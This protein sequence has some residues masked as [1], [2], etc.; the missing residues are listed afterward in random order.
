MLDFDLAMRSPQNP[1]GREVRRAEDAYEDVSPRAASLVESLRAFGYDLATAIAD[2]VDNSIFNGAKHVWIH[3]HWQGEQ[4]SIAIIDDGSGMDETTL[5]EAMRL[6]TTNPRDVRDPRDLGR[7]GLGLKTA[8]FSQCRKVTVRTRQKNQPVITRCWDLDHIARVDAW[9]LSRSGGAAAAELSASL[10]ALAEGTAVIWEKMDRLVAG[11]ETEND[12]HEASF[13]GRADAVREHLATVYHRFLAGPR[14]IQLLLNGNLVKPWDPFL[15][16]ETATLSLAPEKLRLNGAV[17][18]VHPFVLPHLSKVSAET[19]HRAAGVR[20]WDLQQGFYVYRNRRLIVPGDWLGL[21]G[22]RPEGT[23]K[24][25]RIRVDVPNTLDLAW[26]IDVTKSKA[27][28]PRELRAD[29]ERIGLHTRSV[30]KRIYTQRG[31]RLTANRDSNLTFL[32][33]QH[34]KHDQVSYRLNRGHPLIK[35]A[36][37]ECADKGK[38]NALLRLVEET[39]PVPLIM[40]TDREKPD[41]TIGPFEGA[42]SA[43]ILAVMMQAFAAL[44]ATGYSPREAFSRLRGME[45]FPRFAAELEIFRENHNIKL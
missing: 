6:G 34:A 15:E 20:G 23:Y 30:A 32:W 42:K 22:W 16:D 33:E 44:T 27:I 43:E 9:Q 29:F 21:K 8:S 45:P 12:E 18:D 25:A 36:A 3:F 2:L 35:A 37:A 14:P 13:L 19:S 39:L 31:A 41:R 17:V 4:S 7:F 40:V 24:L 38:F 10:D 28:P 1:Q 26:G 11:A 5:V